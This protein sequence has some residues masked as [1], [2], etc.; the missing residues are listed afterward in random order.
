MRVRRGSINREALPGRCY[1]GTCGVIAANKSLHSHWNGCQLLPWVLRRHYAVVYLEPL[2]KMGCA[3]RDFEQT[4]LSKVRLNSANIDWRPERQHA[5][6]LA[7]IKLYPFFV[8]R[9]PR[10]E[11]MTHCNKLA[12]HVQHHSLL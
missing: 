4:E 3:L 9:T 6:Q 1:F 2:R 7:G 5:L 12:K 8:L 11:H 10:C